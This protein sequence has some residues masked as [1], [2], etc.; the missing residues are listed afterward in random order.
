MEDVMWGIGGVLSAIAGWYAL[1]F[2]FRPST[3][4]QLLTDDHSVLG[5]L[6]VEALNKRI[7]ELEADYETSTETIKTLFDDVA[8]KVKVIDTL[9]DEKVSLTR[10]LAAKTN[11]L[12]EANDALSQQEANIQEIEFKHG[13]EVGMYEKEISELKDQMM[14]GSIEWQKRVDEAFGDGAKVRRQAM[15]CEQAYA[16]IAKLLCEVGRTLEPLVNKLQTLPAYRFTLEEH[17]QQS[18]NAQFAGQFNHTTVDTLTLQQQAKEDVDDYVE[19]Q[20][21]N[22]YQHYND[23]IVDDHGYGGKS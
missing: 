5:D 12:T 8:Y 14:Q 21:K 22:R 15:E 1:V 10:E 23:R 20:N 6:K 2:W 13:Q 11:A 16:Q 3:S 17:H 7:K 19:F 9:R 18:Q 4:E